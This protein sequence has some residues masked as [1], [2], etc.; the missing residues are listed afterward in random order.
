MSR[1]HPKLNA[2]QLIGVLEQK[3]FQ[4]S[5]QS[6]SHAIYINDEGLRTTVPIHGKKELGIGLLRQIMKDAGLSS[7]DIEN[8]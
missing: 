1:K 8:A 7:N 3:G 5:R 2:K 6:G 4:F